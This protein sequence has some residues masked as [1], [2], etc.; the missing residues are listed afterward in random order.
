MIFYGC[1]FPVTENT[2][3]QP[4]ERLK[5]WKLHDSI[6]GWFGR[7]IY[8][9]MAR[10]D[11][12]R[13]ITADLGY[14]LFDP[15]KEDFGDRFVNCM[16][17]EQLA[18]GIGVGMALSGLKPFI[19]SITTFL[20]FRAFEWHR[21]YL[22]HENIPVRLV[23]SGVDDDYKH[24]GISHQPSKEKEL[25]PMFARMFVNIPF[26]LPIYKTDVPDM[27]KRMVYRNYP[28][29]ICLRR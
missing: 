5:N 16:A 20:L 12:I 9:E 7:A 21:N 2:I 23:G 15:H 17:S 13:L 6:R 4:E 22:N 18:V 25:I 11:K 3:M 28:S 1:V 14:G 10:D 29:F 24:D 19:Y 8:E 26:Y 27:V